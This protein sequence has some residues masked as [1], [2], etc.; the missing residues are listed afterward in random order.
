MSSMLVI[1][2]SPSTNPVATSASTDTDA[3]ADADT[4]VTSIATAC[5]QFE[6][7]YFSCETSS[8]GHVSICGRN[9]DSLL[10]LTY[11]HNEG[12]R[13]TLEHHWNSA[14]GPD[15]RFTQNAYHRYRTE[16]NEIGFALLD[17]EYKIFSHYAA[18]DGP[19]MVSRG[20]RIQDVESGEEI[21]SLQCMDTQVDE[22]RKLI[23]ILECD[24]DSALGCAD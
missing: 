21:R 11:R 1:G 6:T 15:G 7:L 20:V 22:I 18:E 19:E 17:K 16:Y 5:P 13:I 10:D 24:P 3:D 14:A 8:G 9:K 23:P 4:E 12:G 2:C